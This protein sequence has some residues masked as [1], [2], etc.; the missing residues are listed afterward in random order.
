MS[1]DIALRRE[2]A[3]RWWR[4]QPKPQ[5]SHVKLYRRYQRVAATTSDLMAVCVGCGKLFR[6][7]HLTRIACTRKCFGVYLS[8][9]PS[10]AATTHALLI[11]P[12]AVAASIKKSR[13]SH[14][15]GVNKAG[16]LNHPLAKNFAVTSPD[17]TV[18]HV[19]NLKTWCLENEAL[20]KPYDNFDEYKLPIHFRAKSALYQV[21]D[22]VRESWHG[23][24]ATQD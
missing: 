5:D 1:I 20:F 7:R 4:K 17:G 3:L 9:H 10:A 22:G 14:G 13:G 2:R 21:A 24:V 15:F 8:A 23:W 6:R 18:Y 19:K 12:K 16:N 11:Q